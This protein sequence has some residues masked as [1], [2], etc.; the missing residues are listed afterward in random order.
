[1]PVPFLYLLKCAG[2]LLAVDMLSGLFHWLEDS[3]G[4]PEWPVTG[5]LITQA[6]ILHHF[7]PHHFTRHNWWD[8]ARVLAVLVACCL[9]PPRVL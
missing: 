4:C 7:D 3:Y 8:S 2:A 1:M 5:R 9:E 6:N